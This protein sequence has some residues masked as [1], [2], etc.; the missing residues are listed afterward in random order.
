VIPSVATL[1]RAPTDND[2]RLP[3]PAA[4]ATLAAPF[5]S[6][7]AAL[8][9]VKAAVDTKGWLA[10]WTA[11]RGAGGAYCVNFGGVGCDAAGNVVAVTFNDG[12]PL[13]GTL[14]AASTLAALP[15]LTAL[16]LGN[17]GTTGTLPPGYGDLRAMEDL[18]LMSNWLRGTIPREWA[19]MTRLRRLYLL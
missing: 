15:A 11:D 14:P 2:R 9:A 7:L 17:T 3:R 10:D 1:M 8:L 16:W 13:G 5:E 4:G 18:R 19:G 6:Q 12:D